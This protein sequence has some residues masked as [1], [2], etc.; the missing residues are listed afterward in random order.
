MTR[1]LIIA[2]LRCARARAQLAVL[3]IDAIGLALKAD[4][5]GIDEALRWLDDVDALRFL[6]PPEQEAAA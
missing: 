5:I 6:L 4:V 2:H 1:K 3:E